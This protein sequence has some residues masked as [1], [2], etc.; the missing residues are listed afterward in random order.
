L[1]L[2]QLDDIAILTDI[3]NPAVN[4]ALT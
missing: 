1:A 3:L 4:S 2:D